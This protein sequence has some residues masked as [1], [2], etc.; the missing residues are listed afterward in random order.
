[1]TGGGSV[2]GVGGA[3]GLGAVVAGAFVVGAAMALA[4]FA[5]VVATAFA[6]EGDV[7]FTA[8]LVTGFLAAVVTADAPLLEPPLA[9]RWSAPDVA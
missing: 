8:A 2:V 5:A 4:A 7:D 1:L 3:V 9:A 6:V